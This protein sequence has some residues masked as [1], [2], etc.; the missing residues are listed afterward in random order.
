MCEAQMR[1][2]GVLTKHSGESSLKRRGR[3]KTVG[4]STRPQSLRSLGF[5]QE[6]QTSSSF[7]I[8]RSRGPPSSVVR[9]WGTRQL[10]E[11]EG[12]LC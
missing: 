8:T 11:A 3:G 12:V 2:Q 9:E 6:S 4:A 5:A 7:Q 1:H 10:A